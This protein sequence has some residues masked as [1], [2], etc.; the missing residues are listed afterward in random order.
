MKGLGI[1]PVFR[2]GIPSSLGHAANKG[3]RFLNQGLLYYT[4]RAHFGSACLRSKILVISCHFVFRKQSFK[5][6]FY[7][8]ITKLTQHEG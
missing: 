3:E 4:A 2:E 7:T 5:N 8:G 1:L 6:D